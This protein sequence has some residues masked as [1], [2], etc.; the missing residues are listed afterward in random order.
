MDASPFQTALETA[1]KM[2]LNSKGVQESDG[3][4]LKNSHEQ[5]ELSRIETQQPNSEPV[6]QDNGLIG[7]KVQ[8]T[9]T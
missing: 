9:P 2:P 4:A 7:Q 1:K 6:E 8:T 3:M 5:P